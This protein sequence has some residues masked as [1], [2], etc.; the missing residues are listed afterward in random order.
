[1]RIPDEGVIIDAADTLFARIL[2]YRIRHPHSV[3]IDAPIESSDDAQIGEWA[4]IV[5]F[6][7]KLD[8]PNR[9]GRE[10]LGMPGSMR[11]LISP[12]ALA[13]GISSDIRPQGHAGQLD[14]F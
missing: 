14:I 1:V 2:E 8:M 5:L 4:I 13:E 7:L 9:C 10:C 11:L 12:R 6:D 3:A